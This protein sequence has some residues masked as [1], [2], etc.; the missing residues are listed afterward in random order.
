MLG[1]SFMR[2]GKKIIK[3]R[4]NSFS[5]SMAQQSRMINIWNSPIWL[6]WSRR[7]RRFRNRSNLLTFSIIWRIKH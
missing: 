1:L 7:I 2:S 4:R 3:W 6:I 5:K